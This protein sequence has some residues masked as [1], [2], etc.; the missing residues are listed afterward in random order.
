[1]VPNDEGGLLRSLASTIPLTEH[2]F[3]AVLHYAHHLEAGPKLIHELLVILLRRCSRSKPYHWVERAFVLATWALAV[4]DSE[5]PNVDASTVIIECLDADLQRYIST[6]ALNAARL[7]AWKQQCVCLAAR[8]AGNNSAIPSVSHRSDGQSEAH[9]EDTP[10]AT[11]VQLETFD[12]MNRR[13]RDH[14]VS[15]SDQLSCITIR[16]IGESLEKG[17]LRTLD[18]ERLCCL[19]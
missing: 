7:L 3:G 2:G 6:R 16:D 17:K 18:W 19:T 13:L 14:A 12:L 11:P 1:M 8:R 10:G 15:A 4:Q 5:R 9:E